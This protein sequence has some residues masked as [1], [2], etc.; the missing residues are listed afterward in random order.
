[1]KIINQWYMNKNMVVH[2]IG[3]VHCTFSFAFFDIK[4]LDET[5]SSFDYT[6]HIFFTNDYKYDVMDRWDII[7]GY[8][9]K[10]TIHKEENMRFLTTISVTL[11]ENNTETEI[12]KEYRHSQLSNVEFV[13]FD[14]LYLFE[15]DAIEKCISKLK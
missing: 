12:V 2:S 3:Q 15:E 9:F 11:I 8:H 14:L 4:K 10:L 13:I 7:K 1:M 5:E 6:F